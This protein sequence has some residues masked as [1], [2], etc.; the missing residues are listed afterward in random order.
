VYESRYRSNN[1]AE[2]Y[3]SSFNKTT[4]KNA[5]IIQAIGFLHSA[6]SKALFRYNYEKEKG[7]QERKSQSK[8]SAILPELYAKLKANQASI[9]QF[10][11][12]SLKEEKTPA[13]QTI[14]ST[15]N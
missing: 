8:Y 1:F 4:T 11:R 6:C 2:G 10:L 5:T 12:N 14:C 15:D 13:K 9:L 7:S 3:N